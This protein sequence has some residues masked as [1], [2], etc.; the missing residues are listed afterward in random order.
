MEPT[1][2]RNLERLPVLLDVPSPRSRSPHRTHRGIQNRPGLAAQVV[3]EPR[4]Q[5]GSVAH[6]PL[7]ESGCSQT[8]AGNNDRGTYQKEQSQSRSSNDQFQH[9]GNF[10][11]PVRAPAQ[12][13][14][15]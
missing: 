11:P 7:I 3:T 12:R 10:R 4:N 2:T 14:F 13:E 1:H 9:G 15:C 8:G 5:V 6:R